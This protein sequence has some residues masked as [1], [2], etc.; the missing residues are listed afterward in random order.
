MP[1][2]FPGSH[3]LS[4]LRKN[5]FVSFVDVNKTQGS[6]SVRRTKA[7]ASQRLLRDKELNGGSVALCQ[8]MQ[9]QL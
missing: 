9:G 8:E 3:A 5:V 1:A 4:L 6:A 2:R 7:E